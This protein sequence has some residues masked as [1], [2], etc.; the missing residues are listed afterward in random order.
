MKRLPKGGRKQDS[1]KDQQ[2]NFYAMP[3]VL[4]LP[5]Q[6]EIKGMGNNAHEIFGEMLHSQCSKESLQ[7]SLNRSTQNPNLLDENLNFTSTFKVPSSP[8]CNFE[9]NDA[10][11]Q[12]INQPTPDSIPSM[13]QPYMEIYLKQQQ[14]ELDRMIMKMDKEIVAL[15]MKQKM[16]LQNQY[17]M[18]NSMNMSCSN[19]INCISSSGCYNEND[20]FTQSFHTKSFDP[21]MFNESFDFTSTADFSNFFPHHT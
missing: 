5:L 9:F 7:T 16:M 17:Q 11:S 12:P 6:E 20:P 19:T 4:P 3:K 1:S 15:R 2:P 18:Q 13:P 10:F 21:S 14:N 8:T